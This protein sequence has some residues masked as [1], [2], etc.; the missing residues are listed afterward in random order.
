[1]DDIYASL[2]RLKTGADLLPGLLGITFA[3]GQALN[4]PVVVDRVRYNSPAQL[5]GLKTNDRIIEAEGEKIVRVAQLKHV[6][7]R[8]YDGDSVKLTL[9]RGEETLSVEAKLVGELVPYEAPWLGILPKREGT[10][11]GVGVR[12]V[13]PDSPADKAGLVRGDRVLK[14]NET[15]VADA[16]ALTD[17]VGRSRPGDQVKLACQRDGK[18]AT[19]TVTLGSIPDSVIGE[20]SSEAIERPAT[21]DADAKPDKDKAEEKPAEKPRTGRFSDELA[22]HDHSYWAYVPESYNPAA[23]YGLMVWI[24]PGEDTMEATMIKQWSSICDRRGIIMVGPKSD[25]GRWTPGEA[26]FVEGLVAHLREKYTIDSQRIFLHTYG[27]GTQMACLLSTKQREVFR[28]LAVAGAPFQGPVAD[29][30]PD[31]RQ[32]F[33]FVCGKDDK[34]LPAA[35]KSVD[36]LRK[37]KFPVSFSTVDGLGAKYPAEAQVDEMGRWADSLDRI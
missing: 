3:G 29:H 19:L 18:P 16:R 23:S 11:A 26:K 31:Y 9:K 1:M 20:L 12:F 30:E 8:K 24:Q 4:V 17:M 28:G 37:L 36:A 13:F 33:H 22:G 10:D 14:F 32:Q 2:A 25:Q 5:A 35:K 27:S 6:M 7:G 34:A 15:D 21:A